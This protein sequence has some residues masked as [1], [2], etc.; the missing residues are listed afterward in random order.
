MMRS[1]LG[2]EDGLICIAS[3]QPWKSPLL[4]CQAFAMR[5]GVCLKSKIWSSTSLKTNSD[6][7]DV[8]NARRRGSSSTS[9]RYPAGFT[10]TQI[11]AVLFCSRSRVYRAVKAYRVGSLTCF[12]DADQYHRSGPLT[13]SACRALLALLKRVHKPVA[14]RPPKRRRSYFFSML[15]VDL[16]PAALASQYKQP[17]CS[18]ESS[19]ALKPGTP[20]SLRRG[21]V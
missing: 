7:S 14:P 16:T 21:K 10:P 5:S 1:S 20:P 6:L 11:A 13:P 19:R 18:S 12:A 2:R 4:P 9:S 17:S 8:V 15:L 3:H